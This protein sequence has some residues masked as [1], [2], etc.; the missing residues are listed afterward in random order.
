LRF[1][2]LSLQ[3]FSAQR[4]RQLDEV[5][6]RLNLMCVLMGQRLRL[7][8]NRV[9]VNQSLCHVDAHEIRPATSDPSDESIADTFVQ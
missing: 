3:T 9:G 7:I 1:S 2:T 5:F 6:E 4:D 8:Q